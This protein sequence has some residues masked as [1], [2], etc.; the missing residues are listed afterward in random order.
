MELS[1]R[2]YRVDFPGGTISHLSLSSS[3]AGVAITPDGTKAVVAGS[4]TLEVVDVAAGT[5]APIIL[6]NDTPGTDFHNVAITP[7]G[8]VAVVV[9]TASV[10]FVSLLDNSLLADYPVGNG[11]SVALSPDGSFAYVTDQTDGWVRVVP[12]P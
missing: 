1:S 9:G 4:T 7:D 8:E 5:F 12:I 2:L 6:S 11:T 10:Q 3:S